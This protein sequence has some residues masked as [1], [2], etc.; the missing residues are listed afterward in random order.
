[1]PNEIVAC[2]TGFSV[3]DEIIFLLIE[4]IIWFKI[5]VFGGLRLI[6]NHQSHV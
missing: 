4:N 1:M 3:N 5:T 2:E 6:S